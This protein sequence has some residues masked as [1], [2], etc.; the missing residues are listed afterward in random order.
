M[1]RRFLRQQYWSDR[2]V[3]YHRKHV[4]GVGF[5]SCLVSV[6]RCLW[7]FPICWIL[8]PVLQVGD[9][10]GVQEQ[11]APLCV[12]KSLIWMEAVGME[13]GNLQFFLYHGGKTYSGSRLLSGSFS[14]LS[15]QLLEA[16]NP[17]FSSSFPMSLD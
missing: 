7:L 14:V 9:K 10:F 8:A 17:K 2:G 15:Q 11:R 1:I 13:G 6:I 4:E 5:S 16:G 3:V 12:F